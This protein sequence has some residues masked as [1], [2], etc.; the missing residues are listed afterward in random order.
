MSPPNNPYAPPG[1]PENPYSPPGMPQAYAP[2]P[3]AYLPSRAPRVMGILSIVF[4][5]VTALGCGI[6]ALGALINY[7]EARQGG[8]PGRTASH[9]MD[10][11]LGLNLALIALLG[12]VL[13]FVGVGQLGFKRWAVIASRAWALLALI[14]L[15]GGIVLAALTLPM[16]TTLGW[17]F[18][19]IFAFSPFPIVT[20]ILFMKE[21]VVSVMTL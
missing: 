14:A 5:A 9:D 8:L 1:R 17:G 15:M 18:F 20:L 11:T 19:A 6:I 12:V 21:R 2:I 10:G 3:A 4:G 16:E 7:F 13:I